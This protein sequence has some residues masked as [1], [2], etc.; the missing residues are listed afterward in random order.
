MGIR[1]EKDTILNWINEMGKFLR[2]LVNKWEG[3]MVDVD[4]ESAYFEFFQEKRDTLIAFDMQE[5]LTFAKT[6]DPA[7]IRP[8]A[9]LFMYDGFLNQDKLLLRK[10]KELFEFQMSLTGNYS[11]ED[12][13]LIAQIDKALQ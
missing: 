1:F 4:I 6:L 10:A 2:L 12:Y 3:G 8:L 5:L 7:Q 9:Q 13:G 11:F